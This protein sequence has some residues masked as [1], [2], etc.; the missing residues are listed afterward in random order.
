MKWNWS[1]S[2]GCEKSIKVWR[3]SEESKKL[4]GWQL[5]GV[6]NFQIVHFCGKL[7]SVKEV[8]WVQFLKFKY[9]SNGQV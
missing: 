6:R 7:G 3:S 8:N 9:L 2:G 4:A 5:W 1:F